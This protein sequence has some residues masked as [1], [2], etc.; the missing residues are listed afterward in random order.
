MKEMFQ[1]IVLAFGVLTATVLALF[2]VVIGFV[3][4]LTFVLPKEPQA[5]EHLSKVNALCKV[6]GEIGKLETELLGSAEKLDMVLQTLKELQSRPERDSFSAIVDET[7]ISLGNVHETLD[8]TI[9]MHKKSQKAIAAVETTGEA[10]QKMLDE[11]GSFSGEWVSKL[12]L[13]ILWICLVVCFLIYLFLYPAAVRILSFFLSV[14]HSVKGF[15]LE[16]NFGEKSK[17]N[18]Q[19]HRAFKRVLGELRGQVASRLVMFSQTGLSSHLKRTRNELVTKIN[20]LRGDGRTNIDFRCTVHVKD[21]LFD[22]FLCQL[23]DYAP[24]GKGSGRVWTIF[25]GIIGRVW[26]WEKAEIQHW[27]ENF[28]DDPK[29]VEK[30]ITEYGMTHDQVHEAAKGRL[31]LMAAPIK[32]S[33][34]GTM[35]GVFYIDADKPYAFGSDKATEKKI[36]N[37]VTEKMNAFSDVLGDYRQRFLGEAPLIRIIGV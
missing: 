28:L 16:L 4:A 3:W 31:S 12:V 15:G 20:E 21:M 23:T 14:I 34:T 8:K 13:G 33:K 35:L 2:I 27:E 24:R 5:E 32:D 17:G 22:D 7:V 6:N 19:I 26:R 37:H 29:Q 36:R 9:V 1:K 10:M 30:A 11:A 25:Q 18:E